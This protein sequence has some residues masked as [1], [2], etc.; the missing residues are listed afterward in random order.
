MGRGVA[1]G[2]EAGASVKDW[3]FKKK[4]AQKWSDLR[5][6]RVAPK[7]LK[8]TGVGA[9][10]YLGNLYSRRTV[11]GLSPCEAVS[12]A[13]MTVGQNHTDLPLPRLQPRGESL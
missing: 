8:A 5:V 11:E 7:P 9:E 13:T 2:L 3:N 4:V 12:S 1:Q 6:P 10:L